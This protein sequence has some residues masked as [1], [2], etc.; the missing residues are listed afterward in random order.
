MIKTTT[1]L[2]FDSF[3]S[4]LLPIF[5]TQL[6]VLSKVKLLFIFF[7]W[8]TSRV[9][10]TSWFF[11]FILFRSMIFHHFLKQNLSFPLSG[12]PSKQFTVHFLWFFVKIFLQVFRENIFSTRI[13]MQLLFS[14]KYLGGK[15]FDKNWEKRRNGKKIFLS[16]PNNDHIKECV[17]I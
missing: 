15:Y 7:C 9:L 1:R 5:T 13:R 6:W 10:Y 3:F 16:F 2:D 8:H 11:I 17:W 14:W 12:F 4:L